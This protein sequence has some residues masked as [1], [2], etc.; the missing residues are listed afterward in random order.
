MCH[1]CD[2]PLHH[3]SEPMFQAPPRRD[4]LKWMG[5]AALGLLLP[6]C[7]ENTSHSMMQPSGPLGGPM[8]NGLVRH[9]LSQGETVWRVSKM[10]AALNL[11]TKKINACI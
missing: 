4:F 5:V 7:A 1:I 6:G 11:R 10:Y 2:N 3:E 9:I 8:G